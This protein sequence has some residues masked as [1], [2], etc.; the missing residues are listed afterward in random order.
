M[1]L[2]HH[3]CGFSFVV[4]QERQITQRLSLV[5]YCILNGSW[6]CLL[7]APSSAVQE[8]V[9]FAGYGAGDD[10]PLDLSDLSEDE[11]Y[12]EVPEETPQQKKAFKVKVKQVWVLLTW[13]LSVGVA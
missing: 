8:A 3:W 4:L 6:P 12:A 5:A 7:A 11:P 2:L 13:S 10:G 9:P 1:L